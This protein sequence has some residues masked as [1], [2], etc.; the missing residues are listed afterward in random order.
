MAN[1]ILLNFSADLSLNPEGKHVRDGLSTALRTGNNLWLSCDERS[2]IERLTEQPDGS[3]GQHKAFDLNDYLQL[4]D[5][6]DSEIDIEG[7]GYANHYLWLLGSHSLKRRK[8]RKHQSVAKQ[9]KRLAQLKS[10]PNRYLLARIPI[11]QDKETGNYTL[12]KE[13]PNPGV[14][15]EMLHAAQLKGSPHSSQLL[16]ELRKDEHIGPFTHLPGKDNGFDIEGLA[17]KGNRLFLGLRGPVLRGWAIVLEVELEEDGDHYLKLK[18]LLPERPYK[19][20]FLHLKGK[21]IRELRMLGDD[22]YILAGPTMD[23]DGVIAVYRWRNGATIEQ[24][25]M[26]HTAD[27]ERLCEVAHGHGEDTGKDKAEGLAIYDEHNLM[28]VFDSPTENRKVKDNSVLADLIS[29]DKA[30]RAG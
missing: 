3:F 7:I 29:I 23:L 27:L 15:G 10:D 2:T 20:H 13:C 19:K 22:I 1:S 8:P 21:G 24:E 25:T 17:T 5:K 14:S 26:V 4:P 9:M 12:Y 11:V 6:D 30:A 18:Q 16:D 28:V